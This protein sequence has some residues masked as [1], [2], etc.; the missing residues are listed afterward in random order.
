MNV[1]RPFVL[2]PQAKSQKQKELIDTENKLINKF[3]G[4]SEEET[5]SRTILDD[6]INDIFD[7]YSKRMAIIVEDVVKAMNAYEADNARRHSYIGIIMNMVSTIF[8]VL[9]RKDNIIYSG[10]TMIF[11][12]I[13][14]Y[15]LFISS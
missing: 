12:S 13:F 6:S 10:F 7:N 1:S 9:T 5:V 8:E 4:D 15:Y 2:D 11:I 3:N 14:V